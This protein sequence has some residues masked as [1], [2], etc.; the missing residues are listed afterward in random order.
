MENLELRNHELVECDYEEATGILVFKSN[1]NG[2][3]RVFHIDKNST[4]IVGD[5]QLKII[6]SKDI[7]KMDLMLIHAVMGNTWRQ[8]QLMQNQK[9]KD[10]SKKIM[11]ILNEIGIYN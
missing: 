7:N 1:I 4:I 2:K 10:S 9:L 11:N 6:S 3:V 8:A 5:D